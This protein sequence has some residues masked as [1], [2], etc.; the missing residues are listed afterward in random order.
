MGCRGEPIRPM[1]TGEATSR[2]LNYPKSRG[3]WP[4]FILLPYL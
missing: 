4:F 3:K 1:E 2:L